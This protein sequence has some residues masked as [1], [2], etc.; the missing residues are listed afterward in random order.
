MLAKNNFREGHIILQR[1][2]DFSELEYG[3]PKMT[4]LYAYIERPVFEDELT[5]EGKE[6]F[7]EVERAG[8]FFEGTPRLRKGIF[9]SQE[10]YDDRI[11]AEFERIAQDASNYKK[12]HAGNIVQAIIDG[13]PC[14]FWPDEYNILPSETLLELLHDDSY[15][16]VTSDDS[17]FKLP[18][19]EKKIF[20]LQSRGISKPKAKRLCSFGL[21]DMVIYFPHPELQKMFCRDWEVVY[22][23]QFEEY[24]KEVYGSFKQYKE[25]C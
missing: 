6:R 18:E 8:N 12:V 2:F 11:A 10:S 22:L 17:I 7:A 23:P 24:Y 3:I 16:M 21:K 4:I 14:S 9:E 15:H 20:Y 1:P 19:M 5:P 13:V 25:T